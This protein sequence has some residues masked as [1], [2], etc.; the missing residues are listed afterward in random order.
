MISALSDEEIRAVLRL[1]EEKGGFTFGGLGASVSPRE[2]LRYMVGVVSQGGDDPEH[3]PDR[4][5]TPEI[6]EPAMTFYFAT[7][8]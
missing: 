2:D 7:K 4:S 1:Y 6:L 5:P 8:C 3:W